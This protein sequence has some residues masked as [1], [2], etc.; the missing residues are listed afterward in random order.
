MP[1]SRIFAI[2]VQLATAG[3][4]ALCVASNTVAAD[5]PGFFSAPEA[6]TLYAGTVLEEGERFLSLKKAVFDDVRRIDGVKLVAPLQTYPLDDGGQLVELR[7]YFDSL[8]R[9]TVDFDS[10]AGYAYAAG[11]D[12]V[13]RLYSVTLF[14]ISAEGVLREHLHKPVALKNMSNPR[15]RDDQYGLI[16]RLAEEEA[17]SREDRREFSQRD[18]TGGDETAGGDS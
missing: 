14:D 18:R 9:A 4:L 3:L 13:M 5:G 15:N 16:K 11:D 1:Q 6:G 2:A 8:V 17:F 12:L 7:G 10:G